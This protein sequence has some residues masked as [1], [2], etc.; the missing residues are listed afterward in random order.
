MRTVP[1]IKIKCTVYS[2]FYP[3]IFVSYI[4]KD[5]NFISFVGTGIRGNVYNAPATVI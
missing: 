1:G 2:N 3:V 4:R 5:A